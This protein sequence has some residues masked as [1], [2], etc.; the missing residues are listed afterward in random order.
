MNNPT[1]AGFDGVVLSVGEKE[2]IQ[3]AQR[4]LERDGRIVEHAE[5]CAAGLARVKRGGVC[6]VILDHEPGPF[7]EFLREVN[8]LPMRPR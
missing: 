8:R 3:P 1:A 5:D 6:V 2:A 7:L 4:R